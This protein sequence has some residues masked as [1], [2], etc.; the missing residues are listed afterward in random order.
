MTKGLD[1]NILFTNM[2]DCHRIIMMGQCLWSMA[3]GGFLYVAACAHPG[4]PYSALDVFRHKPNII[5]RFGQ[6]PAKVLDY[7]PPLDTDAYTYTYTYIHSNP[8]THIPRLA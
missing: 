8:H 1:N 5:N 7:A 4:K 3:R 2:S 6:K